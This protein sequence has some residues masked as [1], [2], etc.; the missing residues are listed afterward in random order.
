MPEITRIQ[1]QQSIE[2][3]RVELSLLVQICTVMV[4]ADATTIGVAIQQHLAGIIWA[5]LAFPIAMIQ[6]IVIVL[7]LTLPVLA[8]AV[9]IETRYKNPH[10]PGL[11][12]TFVATGISPKFLDQLRSAA[13]LEH[14]PARMKA[15]LALRRQPAF[16]GGK[17]IKIAL[18]AV[19]VLQAI[20]P[21]LLVHFAHW[22]LWGSFR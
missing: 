16:A 20:A 11:M 4:V 7:R 22:P 15:L 2:T 14:E 19:V 17:P 18:L 1:L 5:G 8:T 10:V 12:S 6:V 13:L 3:Y 21:V 9:S